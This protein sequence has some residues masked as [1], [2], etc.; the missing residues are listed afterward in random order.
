MLRTAVV[1]DERY[2]DHNPGYGHPERAER[3]AA[4][5]DMVESL[6][7]KGLIHLEPRPATSE[8]IALVHAEEHLA[9]VA[10]TAG[11]GPMAPSWPP[12]SLIS[13]LSRSCRRSNLL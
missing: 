9:L 1:I 3:I 7:D 5:R 13:S 4:L 11:G 10:S 6:G 8:E 2:E 12:P